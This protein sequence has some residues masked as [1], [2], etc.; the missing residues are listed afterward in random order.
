[1]IEFLKYRRGRYQSNFEIVRELPHDLYPFVFAPACLSFDVRNADTIGVAP[2]FVSV[3][4]E[5]GTLDGGAMVQ[6]WTSP[7][8]NSFSSH[9]YAGGRLRADVRLSN[10]AVRP[11]AT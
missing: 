9:A 8:V 11:Q 5:S 7:P 2:P 3:G 4:C 6:V 1:M 10:V